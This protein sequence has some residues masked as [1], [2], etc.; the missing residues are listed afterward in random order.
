MLL[1]FLSNCP[2][3]VVRGSDWVAST[4]ISGGPQRL[5]GYNPEASD[6]ITTKETLLVMGGPRLV[7]ANFVLSTTAA[8]GKYL[9]DARTSGMWGRTCLGC[10]NA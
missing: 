4:L 10:I 9:T 1:S 7:N 5:L 8:A 2:T 6:D 3:R